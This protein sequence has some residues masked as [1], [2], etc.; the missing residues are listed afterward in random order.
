MFSTWVNSDR[1]LESQKPSADEGQSQLG[2]SDATAAAPALVACCIFCN[3]QL[4]LG[5]TKTSSSSSSSSRVIII[6]FLTS[7]KNHLPSLLISLR[8]SVHPS[9]Y[10]SVFDHLLIDLQIAPSDSVLIDEIEVFR[11]HILLYERVAGLPRVR[12]FRLH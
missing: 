11:H 4:A 9:V 10:P 3:D 1:L 7:S 12:V 2:R 5:Q 6:F 8:P